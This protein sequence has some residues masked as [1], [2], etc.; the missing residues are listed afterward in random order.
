MGKKV[1]RTWPWGQEDRKRGSRRKGVVAKGQD[2]RIMGTRGE[3]GRQKGRGG[4]REGQ[5]ERLTVTINIE[6][7]LS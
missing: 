1:K 5:V 3:R 4:R 6:G 7:P 2:G